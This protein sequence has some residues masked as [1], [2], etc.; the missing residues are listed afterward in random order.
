MGETTITNMEVD[1]KNGDIGNEGGKEKVVWM[2][3]NL[4][5]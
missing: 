3:S 4:V 1:A 2:E 5:A